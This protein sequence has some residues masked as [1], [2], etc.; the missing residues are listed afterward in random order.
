MYRNVAD[1]DLHR[2]RRPDLLLRARTRRCGCATSGLAPFWPACCGASRSRVLWYVRDLS[3]FSVHGSI[4]AVVAFLV[5]VYLSAVILLYGVEVHR[6]LCQN[7]RR[8]PYRVRTCRT[9]SRAS[10]VR[11]SCSTRTTRWTG[12][13]G[14]TRPLPRRAREDKPIF[15]SIGYSTCHWC[16]VM[17]H[18]SFEDAAVADV[19][20][21]DFVSIKVDREERPDIDRVYMTFVQATTGAGGWPMSVWL[22]PDLKPFFGGTYFPPTSRWGRPGFV[23][24]LAE[25]V[26]AW[27]NERASLLKSADD[28]VDP[29]ARDDR[30]GRGGAGSRRRSPAGGDRRRH[31]GVRAGVRSPPRRV[32]RRAE[33]PT[34]VGVALSRRRVRADGP[35]RGPTNGARDAA[36]DG[37]RRHARPRRRR[38]SPVLGR[39]GVARAALREDALR[40][41]AARARVPRGVAGQRRSVLRRGRR[42]HARLRPPRSDGARWRVLFGGRC[43][44]RRCRRPASEREA[45][46]RLLRLDGGGD[47]SCCS[48]RPRRSCAAGFGVE[49]AGNALADPQGEFTRPEHSLR[50]AVGRGRRRAFGQADGRGHGV[51]AHARRTLFDARAKIARGRIATTRSSR[52]GTA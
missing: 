51:L 8:R 14:A 4:A 5:W 52:P 10:A 38:V 43:R 41:G 24:V 35:R 27:R 28:I 49:D 20:N 22:T 47:R 19:L 18:E 12:T 42:G 40:P 9:A 21:R 7:S 26:E 34:A 45:R 32:W 11:I 1:A 15:L 33:V 31:R 6:G 16:H 17:E 37:A 23:E 36:R 30:R 3:R 46:R 2:R 13:R 25:L 48:A 39:R 50:R 29:A 44:L